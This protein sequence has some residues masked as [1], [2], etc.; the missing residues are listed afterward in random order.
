MQF[1]SAQRSNPQFDSHP[2]SVFP[3][4][5][6]MLLQGPLPGISDVKEAT[7]PLFPKWQSVT[8][9]GPD[10]YCDCCDSRQAVLHYV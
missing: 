6:N 4:R 10:Q 3:W 8:V 9:L 1:R 7:D 5:Q 2:S